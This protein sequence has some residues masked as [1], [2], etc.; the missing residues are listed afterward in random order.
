MAGMDALLLVFAVTLLVAVL[1]SDLAQR[2]ILSTAVLFLLVGIVCGDGVLGLVPLTP[3]SPIVATLAQQALFWV[4]FTDGMRV[5][6]SDLRAAWRLPGRALLLG[7]PLTV[8]LTAALA[9]WLVGLSWPEA[10]LIGAVLAP[11]D[12]VFAAAL[13]GNERV[14]GRLRQLLNVE[15]G[16]ND[17]LALPLVLIFLAMSG[18]AD[19]QP[20]SGTL[21]AELVGGVAIGVFVPYLAVRLEGSRLFSASARYQP[22]TAIAIGLLILGICLATEA[23]LYL[24]AFSAGITIAS[25]GPHQRESFEPI[26]E[27]IAELLKLAA[28]LVFGALISPA[29]L[30]EIPFGGWIFAAL[31]II[32]ARPAAL[33]VSFLGS[34][35]TRRERWTAFWFGPKGFAAVVYGLLVLQSGIPAA[36][37]IF[38]LVALTI[39]LSIVAH[40]STDVIIAR[41]FEEQES[42]RPTADDG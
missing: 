7:L 4:L 21:L 25:C 19:A 17:G 26:G 12:P 10:L 6:W 34:S 42:S 22:L 5:G 41:R 1:V 35:L 33:A 9:A 2:T 13:V 11:T 15:S 18:D 30:A 16:I 39:T 3:D 32:L 14:P 27:L 31:A 23:N 28:L 37:T 38:H 24:A 36:D 8:A 20:A 40:S 29:F